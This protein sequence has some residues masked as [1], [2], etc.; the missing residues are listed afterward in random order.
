MKKFAGKKTQHSS[1]PKT[2]RSKVIHENSKRAT[3]GNAQEMSGLDTK[4]WKG[5]GWTI[6]LL[7]L[8]F[9][10]GTARGTCPPLVCRCPSADRVDCSGSGLTVLPAGLGPGVRSLDLSAN[11]HGSFFDTLNGVYSNLGSVTITVKVKIFT[12]QKY[13]GLTGRPKVLSYF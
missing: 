7:L 1:A 8:A 3:A 4:T 11:R 6:V 2:R 10:G 12:D 5:G 9:G 13:F